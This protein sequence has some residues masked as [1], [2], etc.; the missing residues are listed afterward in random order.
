MRPEPPLAVTAPQRVDRPREG[1]SED[2]E[3][4]RPWQ[5]VVWNDPVNLMS[6]VVW[7]F[8]K[9]FGHSEQEATRLMLAVHHE[10]RAVVASG[11]RERAEA[12]CYRLH[13]H[14]LWATMEQP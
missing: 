14:G 6:Y 1:L 8:R 9:L 2:R 13:H 3:E 7:V 12:D 5:V 10:G 11:P 4:Q